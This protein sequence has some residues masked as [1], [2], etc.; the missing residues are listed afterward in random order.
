M[1]EKTFVVFVPEVH[2]SVMYVEAKSKEEAIAKV[3]DGDG[4]MRE[5]EYSHTIEDLELWK[6]QTDEGDPL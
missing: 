6:V 2:Y 5:L 3:Q 1:D 4:E